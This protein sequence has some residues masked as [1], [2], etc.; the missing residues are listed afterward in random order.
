M[1][2]FSFQAQAMQEQQLYQQ[3]L[4]QQ[5]QQQQR[6]AFIQQKLLEHA[7]AAMQRPVP[8]EVSE[9]IELD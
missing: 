7:K 5:Q 4:M 8:T 2:I 3:R 9:V 1:I 6:E